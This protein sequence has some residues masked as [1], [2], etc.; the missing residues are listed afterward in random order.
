MY[1]YSYYLFVFEIYRFNNFEHLQISD[2][3][4]KGCFSDVR[5]HLGPKIPNIYIYLYIFILYIAYSI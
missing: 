3:R 2:H 1:I 5:D 4:R